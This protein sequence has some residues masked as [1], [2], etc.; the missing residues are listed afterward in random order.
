MA[1]TNK[2]RNTPAQVG[3]DT[4][5]GIRKMI[6]TLRGK[7]MRGY[8]NPEPIVEVLDKIDHLVSTMDERAKKRKGGPVKGKS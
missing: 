2:K 1:T 5:H 4:R 3:A 7:V 6:A 8:P